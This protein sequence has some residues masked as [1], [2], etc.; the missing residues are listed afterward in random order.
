MIPPPRPPPLDGGAWESSD[1]T[2]ADPPRTTAVASNFAKRNAPDS[3]PST[4]SH[5]FII[6]PLPPDASVRHAVL[7]SSFRTSLLSS[8]D[9]DDREIS[10]K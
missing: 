10:L 4:S 6:L 8:G 5:E 3:P 7:N 2:I 1:D 9:E